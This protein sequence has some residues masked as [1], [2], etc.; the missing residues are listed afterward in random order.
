MPDIDPARCALAVIDMQNDFCHPDGAVARCGIDTAPV[1]EIVPAVQS[2]I[3][4]VHR[5]DVPCVFVCVEH[6]EW[7]DDPAWLAR[8]DSGD[9]LQLDQQ[10]LTRRGSWGA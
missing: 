3:D 10:P 6:D 2:V 8:S 9:V 1:R 5:H 4:L 7:S